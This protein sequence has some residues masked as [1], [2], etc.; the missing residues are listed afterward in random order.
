MNRLT[1]IGSI[2]LNSPSTGGGVQTKN[3]HFLRYILSKN[4]D[5]RVFD[6]WKKKSVLSL[7]M[8]L[9][10]IV[11]TKRSEP[12]ILSISTR[13]AYYIAKILNLTHLKRRIFYWV[14]GG[15]LAID[16]K[17]VSLKNRRVY[18]VFTKVVVQCNYL[19]RD[20]EELSI[21]N[22]AMV[23]NFKP[24][25]F[26]PT[27]DKAIFEKIRFVYFSRVLIQKGIEEIIQ[28]FK[29]LDNKNIC[30]DIYGTLV[31]PYDEGYFKDFYYLNI[32]YKGFLDV[33]VE[34]GYKQLSEYDVLLFPT[35]FK[36]EG[37]PGTLL[38]AFIAG[39][40][41]IASDFHANGEVLVDGYNGLLIPPKDAVALFTAMNRLISDI[42][43]R[44]KLRKNAIL[45]AREYD[46]EMILDEAFARLKIFED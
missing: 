5:C 13:G 29:S 45:T 42:D 7:I 41:V 30:L 4:V 38:D 33:S 36:G 20:L 46:V 37:F 27:I 21:T 34:D 9:I 2:Q 18:D 22:C 25:I 12:I 14:A 1:F 8:S 28:A 17:N 43:L 24:V 23:P 6:T 26:K 15:D 19:K 31:P 3:Q 16:L 40:P 10:Y 11:R 39:V 35:Y 32:N 44:K